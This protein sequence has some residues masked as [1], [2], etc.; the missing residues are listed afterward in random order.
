MNFHFVSIFPEIYQSFLNTS[1]IWKAIDKKLINVNISNPRDYTEDK[2]RQVD[3]EIYWYWAWMLLKAKPYIDCVNDIIKYI[4]HNKFKIIYLSPSNKIWN[5]K[6]VKSYSEI[7]SDFIL[8]SWRY[9]WIDFRFEQYL[10]DYYPYNFEKISIWK[11]IMM[12]WEVPSMLIMES[13]ARLKTWVIKEDASIINES[14]SPEK[15]LDNLEHPHYTRPY[16]VYWYKVPDILLSWNHQE[17][18]KWR[19]NN[20]KV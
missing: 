2:H 9:E 16:E 8:V 14:Y 19:D 6:L 11:F 3:D 13:L 15:N 1:I 7:Y 17:I 20:S 5:Q 4:W 10:N 12:W 18:D